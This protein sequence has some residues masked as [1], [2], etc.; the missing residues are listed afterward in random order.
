MLRILLYYYMMP[1]NGGDKMATV[2]TGEE[3]IRSHLPKNY[4]YYVDIKDKTLENELPDSFDWDILDTL[5]RPDLVAAAKEAEY[6]LYERT[7]V[8]SA[9][10]PTVLDRG[11]VLSKNLATK[12]DK[13]L[14]NVGVGFF[15]CGD[16]DYVAT[17]LIYERF[18]IYEIFCLI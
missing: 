5:Q 3:L 4:K 12:T 6:R 14:I 15:K 7:T 9:K 8:S 2:L 11:V 13:K 16:L 10:K 18:D 1:E 17:K